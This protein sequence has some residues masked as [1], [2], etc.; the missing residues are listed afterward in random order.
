MALLQRYA[1]ALAH[2]HY[3]DVARAATAC[4]AVLLARRQAQSGGYAPRTLLSVRSRLSP[5]AREF[6][7][8]GAGGRLHPEEERL[9][10]LFAQKLARKEYANCNQAALACRAAL[11]RLCKRRSE[12]RPRVMS[13]VYGYLRRRQRE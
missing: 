9:L 11:N 1:R 8:Q 2:G 3:R 10:G 12:L 13:T 4:R 7:W 6:G 5:I